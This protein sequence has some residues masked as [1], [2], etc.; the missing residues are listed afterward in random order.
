[1]KLIFLTLRIRKNDMIMVAFK[2]L[3]FD[4]EVYDQPEKFQFDR[5]LNVDG[6]EKTDFY[7]GGRKL[8]QYLQP[9]GM[10]AR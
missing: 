10:G 8:K 9:F 6:T 4:R 5:F 3:H 7:K 1:M 2:L